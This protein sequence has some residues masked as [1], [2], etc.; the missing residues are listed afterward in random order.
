MPLKMRVSGSGPSTDKRLRFRLLIGSNAS[1]LHRLHWEM[2][3]DPQDGSPLC[4][5]E[6]LLFSRY[7][8][9]FDWRPV[10]LQAKGN[11]RALVVISNPAD[12][13]KNKL[14][15]IDFDGELQRAKQALGDIS[16]TALPEP[17]SDEHATLDNIVAALRNQEYDILYMVM[18][19]ALVK[20]NQGDDAGR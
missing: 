17:G 7:L 16:V 19:G 11:L 18:H 4:T 9:S 12:L 3:R 15:P 20:V 6:N 14:A 13:A 10:R 1:E 5:D 2:L 8:S